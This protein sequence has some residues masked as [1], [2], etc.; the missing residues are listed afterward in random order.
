M[1]A[2]QVS[3]AIPRVHARSSDWKSKRLARSGRVCCCS[4][5]S[6]SRPPVTRS[7]AGNHRFL[8]ELFVYPYGSSASPKSASPS[9][10]TPPG[11]RAGLLN[12]PGNMRVCVMR[13]LGVQMKHL[14][15]P[16]C[17]I[18]SAGTCL[19]WSQTPSKSQ[20]QQPS[21]QIKLKMVRIPPYPVDAGKEM[22]SSY[23]A[24]CHGEDGKGYGPASPAMSRGVPDL[25]R[26]A[27]QNR[28]IYPK[29]KVTTA[30]SRFS[31][32]HHAATRSEMPDWYKAFVYLDQ[33][34]PASA[35]VR[36]RFISKYVET[37]Q[38]PK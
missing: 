24:S 13:Q 37:L 19:G 36:A 28:G 4:Q 21:S 3:F 7:R 14:T 33:S 15:I 23:C 34:C 25:T 9:A 10:R 6:A 32:S 18:L 29:Y 22:F 2:H 17:I 8:S 30:M 1:L 26:L 27:S 12:N 20:A 38:A 16:L 35:E 31:D 11:G 5:L